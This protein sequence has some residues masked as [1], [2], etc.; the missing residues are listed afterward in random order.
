MVGKNYS[1][2]VIIISIMHAFVLPGMQML[3]F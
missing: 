3:K 1:M 2:E